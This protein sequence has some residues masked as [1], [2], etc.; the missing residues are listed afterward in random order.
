M[1]EMKYSGVE[2]MEDIP[3]SWNMIRFKDKY[4]SIKEI[5]GEA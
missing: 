5:P 1:R 2:W 3:A 4:Q